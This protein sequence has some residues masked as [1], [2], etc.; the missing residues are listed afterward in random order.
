MD[1][2]ILESIKAGELEYQ[3]QLAQQK[4]EEEKKEKA[5][6]EW[7]HRCEETAKFWALNTLPELIRQETAKGNRSMRIGSSD[8]NNADHEVLCKVEAAKK[9]GL[10]IIETRYEA[11]PGEEGCYSHGAGSNYSVAWPNSYDDDHV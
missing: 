1:S 11:D 10:R 2:K 7:I 5:K 8:Y 9:L 4:I 6:L 3:K